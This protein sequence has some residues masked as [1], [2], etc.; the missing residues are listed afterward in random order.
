MASIESGKKDKEGRP[1]TEISGIGEK[2]LK[3][4]KAAGFNT[5]QDLLR[6]DTEQLL[7]IDGIGKVKA[8]KLMEEAKKLSGSK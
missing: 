6:A 2:L 5:V 7:K 1:L 3:N 4:L 8:K